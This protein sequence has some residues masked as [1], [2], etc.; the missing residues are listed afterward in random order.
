VGG[1]RGLKRS[2]RFGRTP[3][4]QPFAAPALGQHSDLVRAFASGAPPDTRTPETPA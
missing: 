2:I 4:P 3:G 1:Y